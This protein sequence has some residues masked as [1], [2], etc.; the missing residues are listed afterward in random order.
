MNINEYKPKIS[1]V[2]PSFNSG[3]YI[4]E[5]ILSVLSQDYDNFEYFVI[6]GASTD[7]TIDILKEIGSDKRYKD[8]FKWISEKDDGQ[9]DAINKGLRMCSGDW[10]AFI[11]AD[12]YYEPGV[13]RKISREM[14][15][16]MS[17]GVIY[18]NQ[19][20]IFD[21][22]GEK[23][24]MIKIPNDKVDFRRLLYGNKIYGPASFYNMEVLKKVGEFDASLYH[25]M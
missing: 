14:R 16:N 2:T 25:W 9:T 7:N 17:K 22:L 23:Y 13:F 15:D 5:T 10:F 20:I 18:G 6:D 21:G 24:N 11:N 8:K 3:K 12:D 4:E 1:I 19:L